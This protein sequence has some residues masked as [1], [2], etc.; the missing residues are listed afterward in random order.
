M[1]LQYFDLQYLFSDKGIYTLLP[2]FF[3]NKILSCGYGLR[4]IV[5][6]SCAQLLFYRIEKNKK[7]KILVFYQHILWARVS[8][9]TI[10]QKSLWDMQVQLYYTLNSL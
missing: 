4:S 10:R 8:P 6:G 7:K 9:Y 2:C 3:E 1:T 5:I